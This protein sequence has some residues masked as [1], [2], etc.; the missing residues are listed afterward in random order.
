MYRAYPR[1]IERKIPTISIRVNELA[2]PN[3]LKVINN[4]NAH[5]GHLSIF[6]IENYL[7]QISKGNYAS[8]RDALQMLKRTVEDRKSRMMRDRRNAK[9]L[10]AKLIEQHAETIK[11]V[12]RR[13][14]KYFLPLILNSKPYKLSETAKRYSRFILI[15]ICQ[16]LRQNVPERNSE[17]IV[18]NVLIKI[19][20][21]IAL[22][23]IRFIDESNFKNPPTFNIQ[24]CKALMKKC[25]PIE[26][27]E[28]EERNESNGEDI[29]EENEN[30][31]DQEKG[32]DG[33]SDG[34]EASD[35]ADVERKLSFL[36]ASQIDFSGIKCNDDE[37]QAQKQAEKA[38][39]AAAK[40][41]RK[42]TRDKAKKAKKDAKNKGKE[43][44]KDDCRGDINKKPQWNIEWV[45]RN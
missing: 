9:K 7:K 40:E 34:K 41:D 42:R 20:D 23:M 19:A 32:E 13:A 5:L 11:D 6:Q 44:M 16:L 4:F 2:Q 21:K 24:T 36:R 25:Y 3:P 45:D 38:S 10:K 31:E 33:E 14:I 27:I 8:P 1:W 30:D 12:V 43:P 35:N 22:L 39:K 26:L 28:S 18:E 15:K 17:N 37:E 29:E